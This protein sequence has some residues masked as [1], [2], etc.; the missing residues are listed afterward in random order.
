MTDYITTT[1]RATGIPTLFFKLLAGLG[2]G[3]V[4]ALVL[5]IFVLV[6]VT[7][8]GQTLSPFA[9]FAA[10]LMALLGG[11][12]AHGLAVG[13]FAVVDPERHGALRPLLKKILT[14]QLWVFVCFLPVYLLVILLAGGG[15]GIFLTAT[16]QLLTGGMGSALLAHL[17]RLPSRSS[18][19]LAV[20]GV[21]AAL[22][23]TLLIGGVVF[24]ITSTPQTADLDP[25]SYN[26]AAVISQGANVLLFM[27][28]P[29]FW[30]AVGFFTILVELLYH[31]VY[32][33]W[34]V[35]FLAAE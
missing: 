3:I 22:A 21:L 14:F 23:T 13:L 17:A 12:A 31:W 26:Q 29:L 6:G 2:A 10:I 15:A 25:A 18:A 27:L 5:A 11:I 7:A 9:Y 20:Y 28:L 4:G 33:T 16:A 34:G 1:P 24:F 32:A 19:S 8:G 35:D 30:G